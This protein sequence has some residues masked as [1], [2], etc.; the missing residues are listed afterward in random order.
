MEAGTGVEKV[1][2]HSLKG[3]GEETVQEPRE[4]RCW[5]GLPDR[6][7]GLSWGP[8]GTQPT[9][10]E[11]AGQRRRSSSLS[12]DPLRACSCL[13]QDLGLPSPLTDLTY[14]PI[15]LGG[16]L[17]GTGTRSRDES[18]ISRG[19]GNGNNDA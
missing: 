13:C 12:S 18:C 9:H 3:R 17:M 15:S 7:T 1:H 14:S 10:Q 8:G 19:D 16:Y 6:R 2:Y 5:R 11:G 4:G